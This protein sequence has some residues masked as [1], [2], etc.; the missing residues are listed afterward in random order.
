MVGRTTDNNIIYE[1]SSIIDDDVSTGGYTT[2]KANLNTTFIFI[3][4][5]LNIY[6]GLNGGCV[7]VQ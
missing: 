5:I 3:L 1:V 7:D 4:I 6:G 2:A